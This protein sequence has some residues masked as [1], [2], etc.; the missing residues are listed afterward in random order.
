MCRVFIISCLCLSFVSNIFAQSDIVKSIQLKYQEEVKSMTTD[1]LFQQT[2][3]LIESQDDIC[4]QDLIQLT[5]VEAPPF[6]EDKRAEMFMSKLKELGLEKIWKDE[7]GN[8]LALREGKNSK[9][10]VALDAHLDTVFPEGTDVKVRKMGDTLKAPGIADDTRGLAMVLAIARAMEETGIDTEHD[11]LFVGTVGEEGLGDLRGVKY[12]FGESDVTIDSWISIDG[13]NIGR[14]NNKALGSYRY[15]VTIDGPGGHSWGAFGLANPHHALGEAIHNFVEAADNFTS[16]GPRT[17]YNVGRI[18]GGTSINSIPFTSWMEIDIRS[19]APS[20]L[21]SMEQILK[22]AVNNAVF[23]Q[24]QLARIGHPIRASIEKIGDRPSG[25]LSPE[26]P[27]IQ[28]AMAATAYFGKRPQL[29]RGSTNSNIPISR[30][31]PSVTIGRGG[32]GG[33]AHS[34]HEWW[35]NENG[36]EATQLAFLLLM[37]ESGMP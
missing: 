27:L 33:D 36:H 9:K 31:I 1:S 18:G 25:E 15:K 20:R 21:D 13:G 29:T 7:V 28:R 4:V 30:G 12:L 34:L 14:V 26:L 3:D 32:N 17:S 16:Y 5:E 22:D 6:K 2:F 8:V 19:V 23:R 37:L 10:T 35:I 24:N 11:V